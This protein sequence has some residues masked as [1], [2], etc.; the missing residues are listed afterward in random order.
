[1]VLIWNDRHIDS[2]PF[3]RDYEA[4]LR[5]F[6][7]DYAEV[8]HKELDLAQVRAFMGSDAVK[9]T[10]VQKPAGVRLRRAVGRPLCCH[11]P[12]RRRKGIPATQ[13][14]RARLDEIFRQPT[15]GTVAFEYDTLQ[16]AHSPAR[17]SAQASSVADVFRRIAVELRRG[18]GAGC[19]LAVVNGVADDLLALRVPHH[20][21]RLALAFAA[22]AAS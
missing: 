2:T 4:L 22:C 13:P 8:R 6:A 17:E 3:L 19:V 1:M 18:P 11:R 12:M 15:D 16:R 20:A 21:T 14:M 7:T 10:R 9:L 5:T